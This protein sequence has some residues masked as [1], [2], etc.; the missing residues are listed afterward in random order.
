[1]G[2]LG[3]LMVSTCIAVPFVYG[4]VVVGGG[5]SHATSI[6]VAMIFLSNTGRE[7][8]KGIVDVEGDRE[9]NVETVAALYGVRKAAVVSA[10]FHFLA[11]ALTPIPW[12]LGIVSFWYLPFV[13]LTDMGLI[14]AAILLLLNPSRENARRIKNRELAWFLSGLLAFMIGTIG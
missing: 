12:F 1:M 14:M 9:R 7:I 10:A 11:V 8:I 13:T 6:F 3:N 4:S 2:F 5:V